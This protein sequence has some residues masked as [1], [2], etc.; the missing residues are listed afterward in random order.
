MAKEHE[1]CLSIKQYNQGQEELCRT[2]LACR[3]TPWDVQQGLADL[4]SA[5]AFVLLDRPYHLTPDLGAAQPLELLSESRARRITHPPLS[6]DGDQ[7][8]PDGMS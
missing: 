8:R 7:K 2:T 6:G 3:G 1:R 5:L 4:A